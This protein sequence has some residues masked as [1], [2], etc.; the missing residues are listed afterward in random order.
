[1]KTILFLILFVLISC[2]PSLLNAS[3]EERI[4]IQKKVKAKLIE[5]I[6]E[7]ASPEFKNFLKKNEDEFRKFLAMN[8][9]YISKEDKKVIRECRKKVFKEFNDELKKNEL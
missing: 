5:C 8:K 6:N 7:S 1:M 3:K 9:E 4:N 2:E